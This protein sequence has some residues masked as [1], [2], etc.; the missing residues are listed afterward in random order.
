MP[1]GDHL[2]TSTRD[3]IVRGEYVDV[4]SLLYRELEKKDKEDID[5]R[6]KE[7]LKWHRVDSNWA[8]WHPGFLI[9]AG[10]IVCFH[11]WRALSMLQYMDIIYKG[12]PLF[13]GSVWME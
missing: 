3:K 13:S 5:E 2:T 4:F 8:N 9:Y 1:L 12:F 10:V 6:E 11:P 7:R